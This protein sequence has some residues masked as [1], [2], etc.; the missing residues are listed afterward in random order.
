MTLKAIAEKDH[1]LEKLVSQL[2]VL[3]VAASEGAEMAEKAKTLEHDLKKLT[4]ENKTLSD[5][6]NSE[7]V[8]VCVC[9]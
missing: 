2:A 6:F 3:K 4:E 7:R 8:S 9:S 1:E 5:N